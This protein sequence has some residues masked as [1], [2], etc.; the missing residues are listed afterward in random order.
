MLNKC[1]KILKR[2]YINSG[3]I[4]TNYIPVGAFQTSKMNVYIRIWRVE[5]SLKKKKKEISL[6][7]CIILALGQMTEIRIFCG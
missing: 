1:A 4:L 6:Q 7:S 3:Y 2:I 5:I